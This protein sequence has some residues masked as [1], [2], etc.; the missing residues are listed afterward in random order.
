MHCVLAV[1]GGGVPPCG[2]CRRRLQSYKEAVRRS[3]K[4]SYKFHSPCA[5][6]F[7]LAL[8][9][10]SDQMSGKLALVERKGTFMRSN[11]RL[12]FKK[13]VNPVPSLAKSRIFA[14]MNLHYAW[15]EQFSLLEFLVK[16]FI[17]GVVVSAPLGP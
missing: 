17:I 4:R 12:E 8:P 16:G 3:T 6:I 13:N 10:E 7:G 14:S 2:W 9:A 1:V 5:L 15:L 11:A